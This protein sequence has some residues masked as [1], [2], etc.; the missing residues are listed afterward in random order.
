MKGWDL[1]AHQLT[2]L[3]LGY[4]GES[5]VPG[6]VPIGIP[7]LHDTIDPRQRDQTHTGEVGSERRLASQ[8]LPATCNFR[9]FFELTISR[10]IPTLAMGSSARANSELSRAEMPITYANSIVIFR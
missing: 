10:S 5:K 4:Y 3:L 7:N 8:V 9:D 1:G 6:L 2:A